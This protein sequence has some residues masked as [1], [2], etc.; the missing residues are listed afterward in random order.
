M[1][2]E[3]NIKNRNIQDLN[4][5][6][7]VQ[8]NNFNNL[9]MQN[10]KLDYINI[11]LEENIKDLELQKNILKNENENINNHLIDEKAIY[12][13]ENKKNEELSKILNDRENKINQLNFNIENI[14]ILEQNDSNLN[15]LYQEENLKLRNHIMILTELNQ[16]LYNEIDSVVEEDEKMSF[17]LNRKGRISTLL[18]SNKLTLDN[19]INNLEEGINKECFICKKHC[20]C[21]H[22][23]HKTII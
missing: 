21:M 11:Q 13:E 20:G 22:E 23:C 8:I 14:K 12:L 18:L 10:D 19:A 5:E 15:N 6:I 9:K 1:I 3:I 4:C 17:I 2:E 7:R 16:N